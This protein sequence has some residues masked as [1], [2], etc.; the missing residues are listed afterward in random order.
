M[1]K[2]ASNFKIFLVGIYKERRVLWGLARNDLRARFASSALG[3]AWAYIQPLVTLLVMWFVFQ[4][5]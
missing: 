5:G 4:A 1:L 2:M 3:G